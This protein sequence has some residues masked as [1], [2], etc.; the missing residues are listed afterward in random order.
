ML[1][2]PWA[3]HVSNEDVLGQTDTKRT[4]VLIIGKRWIYGTPD[5]NLMLIRQ[6]EG[7]RETISNLPNKLV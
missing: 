1:K 2:I 6:I 7:Q 3:E 5:E 4:L